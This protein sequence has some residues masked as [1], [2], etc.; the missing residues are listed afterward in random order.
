[1]T[2]NALV[3]SLS[4]LEFPLGLELLDAPCNLRKQRMANIAITYSVLVQMVRKGHTSK[5]SSLI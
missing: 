3:H 4:L 5:F 2:L 1:M